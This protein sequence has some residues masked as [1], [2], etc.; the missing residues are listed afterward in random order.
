MLTHLRTSFGLPG[1][2][3]VVRYLLISFSNKKYYPHLVTK[4]TKLGG[5]EGESFT[6]VRSVLL[7]YFAI[8]A[9]FQENYKFS[10]IAAEAVESIDLRSAL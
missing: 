2:R 5:K 9:W 8:N 1:A 7:L 6:Q 3:S 10:P 4:K